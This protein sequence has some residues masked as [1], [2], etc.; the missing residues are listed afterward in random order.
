M[1]I[2]IKP[3]YKQHLAYVALSDDTI[4]YVV[5]GGAAGGGKSWLGA[6]WLMTMCERYP[7][8]KWFIGREELKR[9]MGSSF[10]TFNKVL[11]F[12]KADTNWIL[13][14]Q[15][16]FLQHNN[17]S[18]IDLLD[19]AYKP[20]DPMYER[21]GSLEYTGGWIEEAGEIHFDAFD[22][23]KSRIGRHMNKQYNIKS[24]ILITCNPK[25]NFLYSMFYKPWKE[26][27]LPENSAFIQALYKD[28]PHTADDYGDNLSELRDESKRRRLRNGDW[29]YETDNSKI[30][31]Y[32]SIVD[33]FHNRL[34]HTGNKYLIVDVAGEGKDLATFYV[35]HGWSVIRIEVLESCNATQLKEKIRDMCGNYG[36][37][38]SNTIVDKTGL[39]WAIPEDL[40]CK[41]FISANKAI[42]PQE[43]LN[44]PKF[45]ADKKANYFNLRSQCYFMLSEKINNVEISIEDNRFK[46]E[47]TEELEQIKEV[48]QDNE[49]PL[50]IISKDDIKKDLGRSTDH[51]DNLMMRMWFELQPKKPRMTG[52]QAAAEF[53][54]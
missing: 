40:Q 42:Q 12:H 11:N 5:F 53:Y 34:P 26:G 7:G 18:R 37:P 35:W 39:G 28:N 36:V 46:E 25:K 17:G 54:S 30:M 29:E 48:N 47:I 44:N 45:N 23:L 6:E 4:K 15:Y 16:N 43:F 21:F 24:K 32:D 38:R 49:K 13:N 10:I 51:S 9:L 52:A 33:C 1:E 31:I 27:K 20:S 8:T 3:T 14:G 2:T 19:L 22:V 41:G 50:R